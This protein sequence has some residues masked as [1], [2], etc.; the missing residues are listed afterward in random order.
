MVKYPK[1]LFV[2][3]A[4]I[5]LIVFLTGMLL[6]WS[7]DKYKE[8][9]VLQDL[10]I[11]ELNTQSYFLERSLIKEGKNYCD[12]LQSRVKNIR[13]NL[14][15]IGSQLPSSENSAISKKADLDYLK[16][17]YTISEIQ[18]LMLLNDL[19]KSCG[20]TYFPILFFYTKD[21]T[22]SK[23]QG[24]VLNWINE[25]YKDSVVTLS[26]DKDYEDEPLIISLKLM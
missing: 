14:V 22:L 15:K 9:E 6:G 17:K 3:S 21:D 11:N 7:L 10:K 24:Y 19:K 13:Y 4:T 25:K 5:T 12:I 2:K 18:F 16:R 1:K 20:K 23:K 8:D 26:F